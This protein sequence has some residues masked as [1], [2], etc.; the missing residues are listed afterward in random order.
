M[1]LLKTIIVIVSSY[2]IGSIT[3]GV[4]VAH[5]KK[6]DLR[7]QGSGNVGATNTFRVMGSFYAAVV[8]IGDI[9]KGVVAVL[10]GKLVGITYG[11]D[12]AVL[13]GILAI[14]G[15]NWPIF[16]GFKGGKGI[17]TSLGVLIAL[18][19][20]SLLVVIPLWLLFFVL[21]GYVSLAS[22]IAALSYPISVF[23]FY[24]NDL[25]KIVFATA[26]CIMAV[27][28]HKANIIRLFKGEEH[29]ILYQKKEVSNK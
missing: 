14:V 1:I 26:I 17:A 19:P 9:L 6:V 7:S 23:F 5:F 3:T 27:Y 25:F 12:F 24:Q 18:T 22:I 20:Y 10:L 15:H 13:T 29:R 16:S 21:F 11:F 28:R 8:L 4:I 2:L